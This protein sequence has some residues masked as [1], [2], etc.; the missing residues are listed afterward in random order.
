MARYGSLSSGRGYHRRRLGCSRGPYMRPSANSALRVWRPPKRKFPSITG[1]PLRLG[2]RVRPRMA[3]SFTNTKTRTKRRYGKVTSHGDNQSSSVVS[4]GKRFMSRFDRLMNRKIVSPQVVYTNGQF[5][6]S[7]TTG[8]QKVEVVSLMDKSQLTA[9]ETAANGGTATNVPVKF[10]LRRGKHVLRMRNTCNTNCK[11]TIYDLHTK[12]STVSTALDTPSECWQ[13]GLTDFGSSGSD[14]VGFSPFRSPEFNQFF[15]ANRVTT[16]SLEPG[17]QHDH[18]VYHHW[19]RVVDSIQFQNGV[20]TALAGL[21][22]FI[23]IV[24]HGTLGHESATP[25]NI[26][27]MPITLDCAWSKEYSYGWVEKSTRAFATTD[28]HLKVITDWDF[29]GETGDGDVN[30]VQA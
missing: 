18:T 23:M 29:Q 2:R 20:G 28:A 24:F 7:S 17:Q 15:G 6:T 27:Y 12:K 11:L 26:G 3:A 13:K 21:T 25:A 14:T 19:N 9:M 1:A 4:V 8:L 16:V 10:F 5:A 30:L 22:R